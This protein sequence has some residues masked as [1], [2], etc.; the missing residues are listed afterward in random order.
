MSNKE[1]SAGFV[2][3]FARAPTFAF[4]CKR[5]CRCERLAGI[6]AN[7]GGGT[8]TDDKRDSKNNSDI[9]MAMPN[10]AAVFPTQ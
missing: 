10:A 3:T 9:L 4:S 1:T 6:I 7:F 5:M 2:V 8:K